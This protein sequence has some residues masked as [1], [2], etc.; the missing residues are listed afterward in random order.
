MFSGSGQHKGQCSA[1][2]CIFIVEALNY[3]GFASRW[4]HELNKI[5][6]NLLHIVAVDPSMPQEKKSTTILPTHIWWQLRKVHPTPL[7]WWTA[8]QCHGLSIV[9]SFHPTPQHVQGHIGQPRVLLIHRWISTSKPPTKSPHT[10]L[11]ALR[12]IL[13][14]KN[15]LACWCSWRTTRWD[16]EGCIDVAVRVESRR[17]NLPLL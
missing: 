16:R 6:S 9:A 15:L 17:T 14:K 3:R 1:K 5:G 13:T 7:G 12:L 10:V 8:G 2:W 4:S 11:I